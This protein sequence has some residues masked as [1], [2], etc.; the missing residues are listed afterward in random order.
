MQL[1]PY[2]EE[3]I[4][5][6]RTAFKRYKRVLFQL[7][8][9]GGKS[10]IFSTIASMSGKRGKRV[11]ILSSRTEILLQNGSTLSSIGLKCDYISPR[12]RELP[13]NSMCLGMAQT[14]KRRVEKPEWREF[15][16][17]MDFVIIDECHECISDF[18]HDFLSDSTYILGVT[19][20]PRRYGKMR[21]LGSIYQ[22]MVTGVTIQ[23]LVNLGFLSKSIHYSIIA[24]KVEVPIDN[25]IGDYDRK[26]LAKVFEQKALYTGVVKEYLRLTPHKKAIC[27]CVSSKQAIEVTREFNENGVSAKYILSGSF[28]NDDMYSGKRSSVI[29]D[30]KENQFEV[31]V[32][33]GIA[34]AGFDCPDIEVVIANFATISITKWKQ[35]LGRGARVTPTKH[36]FTILDCG[37]NYKKLG[38][39]EDEPEWC[40]WHDSHSSEGVQMLK[41]CDPN[42][43]D[44]NGKTGCG[45][46]V[47]NSCKVC[48]NCGYTFITQKHEYIMYLEEVA[49]TEEKSIA[50]FCAEKKLDGWSIHRIMVSVCLANPGQ[51]HKAFTEACDA[52]KISQKY[53]YPFKKNVW[54]KIKRK[55]DDIRDT[56]RAETLF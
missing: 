41:E 12:N 47:P 18:I 34:V 16:L 2:Q 49:N 43:K 35:A 23:K 1:R 54:D 53:W 22:A 51:E 56:S 31:L 29:S 44:I 11:L 46:L 42:R 25:S 39:Y 7:A 24:P 15:L 26:A 3:S 10:L 33:V 9:G 5:E 48:P 32:N 37:A 20:T 14:I 8:T 45:Q 40:L 52:L 21:Q 13:K 19:A 30:F 6:I 4:D 27:F 28:D 36:E 38:M 50:Q 55:K 17:T